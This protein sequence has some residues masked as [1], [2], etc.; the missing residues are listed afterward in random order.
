M[1]VFSTAKEGAAT[2]K[3]KRQSFLRTH[4]SWAGHRICAG[5]YLWE[6]GLLRPLY[7]VEFQT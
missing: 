2:V 3:L 6:F 4:F 1:K 7:L 5:D